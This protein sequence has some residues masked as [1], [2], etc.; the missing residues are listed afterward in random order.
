MTEVGAFSPKSTRG[1]GQNFFI[2]KDL[3]LKAL[4]SGNNYAVNFYSSCLIFCMALE[5]GLLHK[6]KA[7]FLLNSL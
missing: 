7:S 5:N 3:G 1:S 4:T 2:L 6:V